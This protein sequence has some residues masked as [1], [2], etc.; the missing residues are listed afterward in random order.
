MDN[1]TVKKYTLKKVSTSVTHKVD[2]EKELNQPQL[3][4]VKQKDGSI[5]IDNS[6]KANGRGVYIC[7]CDDCVR[8]AIKTR[9]LNRAYKTEVSNTI[10]EDIEN[11]YQSNKN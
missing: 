5:F 6:Y 3:E 11:A 1:L 4:A 2:Y 8:K 7:N 9:A 10:Y